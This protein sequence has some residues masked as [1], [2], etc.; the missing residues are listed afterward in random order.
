MDEDGWWSEACSIETIDGNLLHSEC[1]L[2]GCDCP[3]HNPARGFQDLGGGAY[4]VAG[5]RVSPTTGRYV[6]NPEPSNS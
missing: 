3:C 2:T 6:V 1:D 5:A 4:R